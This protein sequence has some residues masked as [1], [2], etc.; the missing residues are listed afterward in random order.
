MEMNSAAHAVTENLDFDMA[1]TSH[2]A[3]EKYGT[4]AER[5]E[6]FSARA[7][8][9]RFELP[10]SDSTW[11]F[12][13]RPGGWIIAE[14]VNDAGQTERRRFMMSEKKSRLSLSLDGFIWTGDVVSTSRGTGAANGSD[15]DL[16]AQFPGKVR[17]ILVKAGDAVQAGNNLVLVEAMKMEFAIKA[18][19][20]GK[21]TRFLVSEGQQLSPGDR[22]LDFEGEKS[23]G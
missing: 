5:R 3:L 16:I 21:V 1:W 6:G 2:E 4:V 9:S 14:R 19:A 18:P 10:K 23:D 13:S 15:A 17:K 7:F 8:S 11:K 12:T 20:N 22:F